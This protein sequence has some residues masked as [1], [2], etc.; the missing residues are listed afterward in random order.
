MPWVEKCFTH[1]SRLPASWQVIIIDNA[2][3]DN[4]INK[5]RSQYPHFV[6]IENSQNLGF[7]AANNIGL[8]IA[9]E[10]CADHVLLLNQDAWISI[11]DIAKLAQVQ[12]NFPDF[13]IVSPLHYDATDL[14][15]DSN[16]TNYVMD[17]KKLF[18]D[19]LLHNFREEVYEIIFC[20]A[21]IWLL[22]S[23]C[24]QNIGGFN[25][26][27]FHYAEDDNYIHRIAYQHKKVGLVPTSKAHHDR[28]DRP[29]SHMHNS[30]AQS[31]RCNFILPFSNPNLNLY[32]RYILLSKLILKCC[33]Y[34]ITLNFKKFVMH[35][36]LINRFR[37]E[38]KQIA[39]NLIISKKKGPNF[40]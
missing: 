12:N 31:Y 39:A 19:A 10:K 6:I 36:K 3:T 15:L 16:F 11:E 29:L 37:I 25:P 4:C 30:M 35:C 40:L 8:K 9:L 23:T 28:K 38:R 2:S 21:A 34:F 20:N 27:F 5:I 24:I 22:S 17:C 14:K 33:I 1:F 26:S 7:G 32:Q 18:H 13:Y